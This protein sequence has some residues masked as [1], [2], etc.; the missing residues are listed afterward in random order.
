MQYIV[1]RRFKGMAICG[2]V[3][4]P[5][6]TLLEDIDGFL[7]KSG[8]R[9]CA[10]TSENCKQ[11]FARNDDGQGILRGRLSQKIISILSKRD[12]DY[13]NRW[14]KIW[15]DPI[16]QKFKSPQHNDF[17]CWNNDFYQAHIFD[18]Q[19]ILKLIGGNIKDAQN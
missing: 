7:Y 18:L 17:W 9:I 14:D 11:F 8:K 6:N 12:K 2:E 15:S 19:H 3:N 13:Q 10:D 4:L 1:H 16:C 5:V